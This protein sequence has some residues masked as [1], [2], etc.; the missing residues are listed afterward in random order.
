MKRQLKR[1]RYEAILF[2]K[3]NGRDWINRAVWS[4]YGN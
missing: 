2:W 1:Q 4:V 3:R